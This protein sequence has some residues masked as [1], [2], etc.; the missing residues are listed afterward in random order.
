MAYALEDGFILVGKTADFIPAKP[1]PAPISVER[2]RELWADLG[3]P[4]PKGR[5]AFLVLAGG[6][7][8]VPAFLGKR[9]EPAKGPDPQQLAR[10]LV[11]LDSDS[12]R[13]PR[14]A[15]VAL[16]DWGPTAEL[17]LRP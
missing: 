3:A 7:K 12:F 14:Q 6:D 5:Q 4:G 8:A 17:P 10:W 13:A 11:Q 16:D 15:M 9:L 2:I 1:A